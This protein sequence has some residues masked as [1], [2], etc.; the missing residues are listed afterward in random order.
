MR[1]NNFQ[2]CERKAFFCSYPTL[3]YGRVGEWFCVMTAD[4]KICAL[5]WA[6]FP[7]PLRLLR[8]FQ[9]HKLVEQSKKVTLPEALNCFVQGTPFQ[10][11][12][13]KALLDIPEGETV[14]YKSLAHS[15]GRPKAVR[16]VANAVG[17]NPISPLIPCHRVIGTGRY[18][19]GYY[20]G[21]DEKIKLLKKEGVNLSS[22]KNFF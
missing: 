1:I 10:Y 13:W 21:I 20:W 18:L 6:R 11:Q 9:K 14:T 12:V 4:E 16:A 15:L 3:Y 8:H 19:G 7:N 2:A 17:V 5:A 22:F